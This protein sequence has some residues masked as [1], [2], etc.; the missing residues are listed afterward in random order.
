MGRKWLDVA[1]FGETMVG[2][3]VVLRFSSSHAVITIGVQ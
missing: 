1:R 2:V 3:A